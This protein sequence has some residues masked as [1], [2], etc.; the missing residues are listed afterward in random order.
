MANLK[1]KYWL[2][3]IDQWI[4]GSMSNLRNPLWWFLRWKGLTR[5]TVS[6]MTPPALQKT[7]GVKSLLMKNFLEI[8]IDF[9]QIDFRVSFIKIL[10][11]CSRIKK[12]YIIKDFSPRVQKS[13]REWFHTKLRRGAGFDKECNFNATFIWLFLPQRFH[14]LFW[15]YQQLVSWNILYLIILHYLGI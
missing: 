9:R 11:K 12:C 5:L 4:T 2:N 6:A 1:F 15:C 3:S 14:N 10:W 7:Y 8:L 13:A